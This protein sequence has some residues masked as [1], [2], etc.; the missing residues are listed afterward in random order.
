MKFTNLSFADVRL[1][2]RDI[3]RDA[4]ETFGGLD[5]RR[6]NWRP[7]P[8]KWSVA[9]CFDHLITGNDLLIGSAKDALE[10]PARSLWQQVPLLPT[11]FGWALIR[12]Q[13]PGAP[14]KYKAPVKARPTTSDLP[15]DI[16][17]RFAH[18]HREAAYWMEGL[19]ERKMKRV[20]MVSP[21][22]RTITYSVLDGCRLL[23]AH[24]RRHFEQARRVMESSE[25]PRSAT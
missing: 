25:F 11:A 9:Q 20:I 18:Q 16:I 23:L 8:T 21:F 3:A 5:V 22:V 6:L 17:A 7:A 14:G 24:D 19:D 4:E 1:G 15:G 12:S 10:N 13:A 2:L